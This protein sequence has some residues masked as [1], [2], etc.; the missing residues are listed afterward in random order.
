MMVKIYLNEI[1]LKC[2][3]KVRIFAYLFKVRDP[4]KYHG[5]NKVFATIV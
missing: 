2:F 5:F 3:G 1:R 4:I